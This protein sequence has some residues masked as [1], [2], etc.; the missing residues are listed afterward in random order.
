MNTPERFT[1]DDPRWHPDMRPDVIVR[2]RTATHPTGASAVLTAEPPMVP[3]LEGQ[4]VDHPTVST[5]VLTITLLLKWVERVPEP[6][7]IVLDLDDE[8]A[9]RMMAFEEHGPEILRPRFLKL[10]GEISFGH[11]SRRLGAPRPIVEGYCSAYVDDDE[12]VVV[13]DEKQRGQA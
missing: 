4:R 2:V 3:A 7:C 6:L 13:V 9:D 5:T 1:P 11:H 8:T 10:L 12:S